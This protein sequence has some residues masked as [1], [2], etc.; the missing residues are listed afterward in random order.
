VRLVVASTAGS[1]P[2][3]TVSFSADATRL[4]TGSSD[5][6]A[7]IYDLSTAHLLDTARR[8]V[9]R[10]LTLDECRQYLHADSCPRRG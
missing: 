7:R 3:E 10:S 5:G 6:T 9:T 2:V 8:R 1:A 4:L